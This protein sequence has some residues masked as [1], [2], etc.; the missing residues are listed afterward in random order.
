MNIVSH[1]PAQRSSD[2]IPSVLTLLK[3]ITL[4]ATNDYNKFSAFCRIVIHVMVNIIMCIAINSLSNCAM[5]K[6][7]RIATK[8][9]N[10]NEIFVQQAAMCLTFHHEM[11]LVQCIT[12]ISQ[13]VTNLCN[14]L[15]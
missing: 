5:L 10:F 3:E 12:V 9:I 1:N 14:M 7:G 4:D 11:V 15:L 6:E 2:N 13:T 8:A